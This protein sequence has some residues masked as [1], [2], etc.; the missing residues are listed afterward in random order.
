[1]RRDPTPRP[2]QIHPG[3]VCSV[4]RVRLFVTPWTV[5]CQAPLSI[6]ILHVRILER[7]AF[8]SPGDLPNLGIEL[9]SLV[10]PILQMDSFNR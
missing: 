5:A 1:M 2:P 6:R 8:P 10:S 3:A 4:G 7:V 9:L